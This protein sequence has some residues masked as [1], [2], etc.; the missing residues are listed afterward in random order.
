VPFQCRSL[1]HDGEL[2]W[3]NHRRANETVAFSVPGA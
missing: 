1:A 2:F 3:S